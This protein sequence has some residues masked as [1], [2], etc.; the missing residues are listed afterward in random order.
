MFYYYI[1]LA[2]QPN[3]QAISIITFMPTCMVAFLYN[4]RYIRLGI[5]YKSLAE[6]IMDLYLF[7]E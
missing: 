5:P 3:T 6:Y 7:K 4:K 2:T 1:F